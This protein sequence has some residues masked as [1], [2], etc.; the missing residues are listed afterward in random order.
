M[1][2]ALEKA[3]KEDGESRVVNLSSGASWF[4]WWGFKVDARGKCGMPVTN[5][6]QTKWCNA[7]HAK[8]LARRWEQKGIKAYSVHPGIIVT[9]VSLS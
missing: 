6:A 9:L 1:L 2:P 7:I 4:S 8:M 5:Y 3:V